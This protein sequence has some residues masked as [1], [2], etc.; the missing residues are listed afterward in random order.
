MSRRLMACAAAALM[1]LG[2][3]PPTAAAGDDGRDGTATTQAGA[4]QSPSA[5]G[6]GNGC[7]TAEQRQHG[8]SPGG[9]PWGR[10]FA[11]DHKAGT[12]CG[13]SPFPLRVGHGEFFQVAIV[14][15]DPRYF[16]YEVAAI[17]VEDGRPDASGQRVTNKVVE[18]RELSRLDLPPLQHDRYIRRYR[19]TISLAEGVAS[20]R[21]EAAATKPPGTWK[22]LKKGE[23]APPLPP[24]TPQTTVYELRP[25]AFDV[26]VETS[27]PELVFNGGF[28]FSGL[29]DSK[30]FI[31]P[32]G[33]VQESK[34]LRDAYEPDAVLLASLLW[35]RGPG[36]WGVSIG[37]GSTTQRA[38]RYYVGGSYLLGKQFVFNG[39]VALGDTAALP[40]GQELNRTAIGGADTL[41]SLPRRFGVSWYVGFAF[42]FDNRKEQ[43]LNQLTTRVKASAPPAAQPEEKPEEPEEAPDTG[44][45]TI[46]DADGT[47]TSADG[48]L[49]ASVTDGTISVPKQWLAAATAAALTCAAKDGLLE[50]SFKAGDTAGTATF[51]RHS[52]SVVGLALKF[53]DKGAALKR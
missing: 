19:V 2:V 7:P 37:L 24:V 8:Q 33:K 36:S 16:N 4:G 27:G 43:F 30:Y 40:A 42:A 48:E 35:P 22:V 10:Y 47:Y 32:D 38:A 39:G 25:V 51:T 18:T 46:E 6:G 3:P 44:A 34:S 53:G 52:G 20:V 45:L 49:E 50:C 5:S 9:L 28:V 17:P 21:S 29:R 12:P 26:A 41:K 13:H 31:D 23:P 11:Y 15:T 1:L 14:N